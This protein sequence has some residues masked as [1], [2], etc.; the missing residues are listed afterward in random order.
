MTAAARQLDLASF[1]S[2]DAGAAQAAPVVSLRAPTPQRS[3]DWLELL[4]LL[5]RVPGPNLNAR[6][7]KLYNRYKQLSPA[8]QRKENGRLL[9]HRTARLFKNLTAAAL[10]IGGIP[11]DL[12]GRRLPRGADAWSVDDR[13]RFLD[14][15]ALLDAWKA[16]RVNRLGVPTEKLAP[17]FSAS[18]FPNTRHIVAE[19][20]VERGLACTDRALRQYAF[21]TDPANAPPTFDEQTGKKLTQGFDGNI[22]RRGSR[23]GPRAPVAPEAWELF[24]SLIASANALPISQAYDFVAGEAR[25]KGWDWPALETIRGK[26]DAQIPAAAMTLRRQGDR[27]FEAA[28]VPKMERSYEEMLAGECW[29]LDAR[30]LDFPCRVPDSRREW[31]EAR[32]TIAGV[33]DC[34]SRSLRLELRSTEHSDGILAGIK[35]AL[36]DWG[37]PSDI[38]CD[39]GKAYIAALL[40][41]GEVEG[42]CGTFNIRLHR[43][44]KYHAWAK[45]IESLW[46]R[47][48]EFFD[49]WLRVFTGG[50]PDERP[51]DRARDHRR[52]IMALPTED[53]ARAWI[54][55]AMI[56]WHAREISGSGTLG[57][58]PNLI[59]EQNRAPIRQCDPA[60]V[61]ALCRRCIGPIKKTRHGFRLNHL[62]F[63][64]WDEAVWRLPEG[65]YFLLKDPERNDQVI[66]A[67]ADKR[68]LCLASNRMLRGTTDEERREAARLAARYRKIM[69][70][71]LPARDFIQ[72]TPT[73]QIL[74]TKARHA[75]AR[76]AELRKSLPDPQQPTVTLVRPDLVEPA[77]KVLATAA[78]V[79]ARARAKE[80]A[81]MPVFEDGSIRP[82][83]TIEMPDFGDDFGYVPNTPADRMPDLEAAG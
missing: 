45:Q 38:I 44:I 61:E 19:W 36:L 74:A 41:S 55:Q 4:D 1:P 58:T 79:D 21:R 33:A 22:D 56:E 63:G 23:S 18:V 64:R 72:Q 40:S 32:F 78:T 3:D 48:K 73:Q 26:V 15:W 50:A 2:G 60:L 35:R 29:S 82:R 14:T 16:F 81:A 46:H 42:L 76:E 49:R 59:F 20:C 68:P 51:Q 27:K 71:A 17:L 80:A 57:L 8:L 66:V 54:E 12:T 9:V 43:T 5:P 53:E 52:N 47:L 7:V 75:Q 67:D 11:D 65:E 28:H 25:V 31:K 69:R 70:E 37:A 34:R 39:N 77:R 83:R 6:R 13:Q 62:S 10:V 30:T 24:L